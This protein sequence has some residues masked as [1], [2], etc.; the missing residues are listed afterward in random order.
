MNLDPRT[1]IVMMSVLSLSF[2][3]LLALA[4]LHADNI[5]GIRLWALASLLISVGFSAAY[6]MFEPGDGWL[7]T[8]SATLVG[9]GMSLQYT[10]IQA[11]KTGGC[12][13]RFPCLIAV[14]M[15]AQNAWFNSIHP[16]VQAR[17]IANS[18][19]MAVIN[20]VCA[21]ALLIRIESPL[22]TAYWFTGGVFV[23]QAC[24]ML[25]RV[26]WVYRAPPGTYGLY[27]Q[28][29][30]NPALFFISSLTQLFVTFG[31]VLM[32]NYRLATDLHK[33]ALRDGLTGALN[34]RCLE[35]EAV[36]LLARC[37]RTGETL[38]VMMIDIDHFKAINDQ[39]GHPAGDET[40]RRLAA[41]APVSLRGDDYFARY[42]GEEFCVL[43]PATGETEAFALAERLRKNYAATTIEFGGHGLCSTVSIGVAD[44]SRLGLDFAALV[45]AA[46]QAMYRAK[47]E[48][49]NR[50][51]R[52]SICSDNMR[53]F[54]LTLSQPT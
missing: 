52:Y 11:F 46:D 43:L 1:M 38:A 18:S 16:D 45:A 12:D 29:P 41:I 4:G 36:H 34:R 22:R 24:M 28:A 44:S 10:G 37:R 23:T 39:Y 40:L 6:I 53:T 51:V 35:D 21:R 19:L 32:L 13:W 33:L 25:A 14:W 31:F 9:T 30:F 27:T 26:V 5:R 17:I 50:V 15:F 42:G 2:S 49:R 54:P 7:I 3:G 47:Q 20:V 8:G 48:G